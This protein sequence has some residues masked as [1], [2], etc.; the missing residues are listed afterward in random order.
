MS[1]PSVIGTI[2]KTPTLIGNK[3][4]LRPKHLKDVA[5]DYKWRTDTELCHLDAA[6][7]IPVSF[8]QYTRNY[9]EELTY[10]SKACCLAIETIDGKHIGNC[11]YF[12]IDDSKREAELGIMIGDKAYWDQGY[13]TDVIQTLLNHIFLQTSIQRVY[14]KTLDWN[15]RAHQCFKKCGFV[16]CGSLINGSYHFII[17]EIQRPLKLKK[18][19]K[20]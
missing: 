7:P 4:R 19:P 11:S 10:P 14:L 8:E 1:R 9:I 20:W 13:G 3:A 12:K 17:M 16:P 5:N 15:K 6:L 2:N 18:P